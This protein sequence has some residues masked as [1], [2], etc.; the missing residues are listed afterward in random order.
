MTGVGNM[1]KPEPIP[2]LKGKNARALAERL[3]KPR[4]GR[5]EKELYR[6]AHKHYYKSIR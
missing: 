1:A 4:I 6:G 5:L 3:K 2:V